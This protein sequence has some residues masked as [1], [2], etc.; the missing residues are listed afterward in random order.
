MC[1]SDLQ[2]DSSTTRQFGGTGLGLAISMRLS[3]MMG[4][5]MWVESREGEGST[6][7]FTIRAT[8]APTAF[9]RSHLQGE[10]PDLAGRRILIV[11]DNETNRRILLRQTASWGM[12]PEA[13]ASGAEALALLRKSQKYDLAALDMQMPEMDGAMLSLE[14]RRLP[15]IHQ[16]LLVMLTSLTTSSRQLR[17]RYDGLD[18]AAFLTK[19]IK[20]SQL[21]DVLLGLL[22]RQTPL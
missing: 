14:I 16:P 22:S 12:L 8:E 17:E 21:Y 11:D 9:R 13:V 7:Y 1:S 5:T 18:F 15:G 10:Q 2:V 19:P 4:G 3:E 6:F 20:P